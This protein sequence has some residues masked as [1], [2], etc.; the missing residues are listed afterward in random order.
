MLLLLPRLISFESDRASGSDYRLQ[1]ADD[2]ILRTETKSMVTAK[3]S[4][5]QPSGR[6]ACFNGIP[7]YTRA[8]YR[9]VSGAF[10]RPVV[11]F[12]C[13]LPVWSAGCFGCRRCERLKCGFSVTVNQLFALL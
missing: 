8:A 2:R 1:M 11:G 12:W 3:R 5:F 4:L 7:A 13:K 6:G 9:A 10:S